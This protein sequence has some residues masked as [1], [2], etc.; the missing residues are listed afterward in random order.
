MRRRFPALFQSSVSH[1]TQ[2]HT[3]N[4]LEYTNI[5]ILRT[6]AITPH[7]VFIQGGSN[8][9]GTHAACLHRN[10]S[11]SYLNHLVYVCNDYEY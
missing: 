9:T 2:Y 1:F 5:H 11:R 4:I 8:M 3:G 6:E 7:F 10:Q